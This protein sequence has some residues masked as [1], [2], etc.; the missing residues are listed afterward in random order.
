[1]KTLVKFALVAG[2]LI[3]MVS[4][5]IASR[6]SDIPLNDSGAYYQYIQPSFVDY[7]RVTESWLRD[8]RSYISAD[9]DR[10]IKMNMP[11]EQGD[12][13]NSDKAILL[14]HGLGDSPYSFVD[15]A[16]S[17][18]KDGFY[19]QTLLLPGHGS[20]PAD[21]NLPSYTDWQVFVDHYVNLLKQDFDHV[22]LGGYSTG[23]N[24]V[25][26]HA[27]EQGKVDGLMLFA[28]GFQ[29]RSHELEKFAPLLTLFTDGWQ[30]AEENL[31][32]YTSSSLNGAIAYIESAEKLRGLLQSNKV[33][34]PTLIVLSE[35]DS[36]I[37]TLAVK[38][39]F[40]KSFENPKNQL[41]WYGESTFEHGVISTYTMKLE[42]HR[43]ST[44]SHMSLTFAPSNPYYGL[45]G[46]RKKCMS[47]LDEEK[48]KRCENG[49]QMWY[50]AWGY[51]EGDRVHTRLTWNP[52]YEQLEQV[53]RKISEGENK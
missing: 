49:E 40:L 32:R 6:K 15:I 43:I 28:P 22:W 23:G 21:L 41:I 29:S 38:D 18:Q 9:H 3:A 24:L 50:S 8:N 27:I 52:Y 26:L 44:G 5:T 51:E 46:E 53:M 37:D 4:C 20:K 35:A 14:V 19:V 39:L 36:A 47:S 12:K 48:M 7:L 34:V 13:S 25:T 30:A 45:G 31:A 16:S 1:M 11:F 10:E 2:A 42:E 17:L 33:T